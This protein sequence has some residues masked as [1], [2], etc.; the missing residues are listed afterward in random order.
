[1]R[2][3]TCD[4]VRDAGLILAFCGAAA[5][6][7]AFFTGTRSQLGVFHRDAESVGR[8]SRFFKYLFPWGAGKLQFSCLFS[9]HLGVFLPFPDFCSLFLPNTECE[10][11]AKGNKN[12]E[13]FRKRPICPSAARNSFGILLLEGNKILKTAQ[14]RP[15]AKTPSGNVVTCWSR[16]GVFSRAAGRV[17]AAAH[18]LVSCCWKLI[19]GPEGCGCFVCRI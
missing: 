12:E 2:R 15:V 8:F 13:F 3:R 14:K 4:N 17:A 10:T 18:K 16:P 6:A 19:R 7:W 5:M 9:Y 11:G 1:M